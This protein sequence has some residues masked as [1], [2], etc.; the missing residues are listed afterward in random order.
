MPPEAKGL[1]KLTE[2]GRRKG[3]FSFRAFRGSASLLHLDFG[4][5]VLRSLRE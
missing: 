4:L 1:L 2:A 5:L 3:R